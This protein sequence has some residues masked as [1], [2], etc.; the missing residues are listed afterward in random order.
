MELEGSCR[1]GAVGF[2]VTSW[3]PQPYMRCYCSICRKQQGGGGYAINIMGQA[4]TLEV[5]GRE[6]V[7]VYQAT[8]EDEETGERVRSEARR[9][10][11]GGCGAA[12]WI[13]DPSWPEWVYPFASAVDTPLPEPVERVHIMLDFKAPWVRVPPEGPGERWFAR[14]PDEAIVDWHKRHGVYEGP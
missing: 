1:C 6:H 7:R 2:R 4:D 14:Y 8:L 10:F 5:R 3:T 11:C 12:L 9:H 13:A